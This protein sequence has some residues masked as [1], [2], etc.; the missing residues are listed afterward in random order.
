M[1]GQERLE[2]KPP[3]AATNREEI[4]NNR[5]SSR[6]NQIFTSTARCVVNERWLHLLD[7]KY[8]V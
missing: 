7:V 5:P 6:L 3:Q 2:M 8:G 4:S 1:S